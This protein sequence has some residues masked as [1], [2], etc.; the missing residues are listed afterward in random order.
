MLNLYSIFH[1]NLAYSS[2]PESQRIEVIQ[3]CFWPLLRLATEDGILISIEAPAYTLE[4]AEKLD[5]EWVDE[6][7]RAISAKKVEFVGS[8]YSQLI[9]PLVP[10]DVNVWNLAIGIELY[11]K[12]L[13]ITPSVWFINEQAYSRG[14]VEHYTQIGAKGIIMEWNNPRTLHPEW[15]SEYR[16][17]PQIAVG[18]NGKTIPVLWNDSISFQKFQR[19]AHNDIGFDEVLQYLLDHVVNQN[20]Y[21]CLYGND[22][23]IFDF[24][25]GRFKT[26]PRLVKGREWSNIRDLY[27]RLHA[28]NRFDLVFPSDIFDT[29]HDAS[30]FPS[31]VFLSLES[32]VQPIPVKKQPKYNTTRWQVTGRN[33]MWLNAQ[34]YEIYRRICV[35]RDRAEISEKDLRE[36]KKN[37]CYLWSSDF[38]T[39]IVQERWESFLKQIKKTLKTLKQTLDPW[40]KSLHS[41]EVSVAVNSLYGNIFLGTKRKNNA[42]DNLSPKYIEMGERFARI[43]TPGVDIVLNYDRGLAIE[44]LTFPTIYQKP[45]IGTIKHGYFEEISLT[46]DWYSASTVLQRPGKSQITDLGE[47]TPEFSSGTSKRGQWID[48]SGTVATGAGS[49]HKKFVIYMD[50]PQIDLEFTFD[51][52]KVPL[53]S[54]RSGFVTLLPE[55]FDQDSLFYATHNGGSDFEIFQM[56]NHS[57]AHGAPSSSVVTASSGLGATEGMIVVGDNKKGLAVFFDQTI[58]ATMPMLSFRHA[59][60][61]FFARLMFS[62]G[63]MDESRTQEVPGPVRFVCS[64][65][66]MA[67]REPN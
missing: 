11:K 55:A 66:G 20:R 67:K 46:A 39:H 19:Y 13:N 35:A 64:L 2:I 45:L 44:S 34:C 41:N 59:N 3:Q 48:C 65:A 50:I 57:I 24:R 26:E 1:L 22:A 21:F 49:I 16:Y 7:K 4:V 56:D 9:A 40:N 23:E 27:H 32:P 63:E 52:K 51:W 38:R 53:G 25:P 15:D 60:P 8:G 33:S 5:P 14:I 12:L 17:Y 6:L 61:S 47:T 62:L 30:G 37:L 28:D 18:N 31:C 10:A 43:H 42:S 36:L 54:F 58:C 29:A